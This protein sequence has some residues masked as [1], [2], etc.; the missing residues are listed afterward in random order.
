MT[1][2]VRSSHSLP[3]PLTMPPIP[4]GPAFRLSGVSSM[5][6]ALVHTT[7]IG[8]PAELCVSVPWARGRRVAADMELPASG[9]A[10]GSVDGS[11]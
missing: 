6:S 10:A 8:T 5:R 11:V 1:A 2:S 3:L 9:R 4:L 7:I